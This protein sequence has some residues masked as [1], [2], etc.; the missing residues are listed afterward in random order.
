MKKK[1]IMGVLTGMILATSTGCTTVNAVMNEESLVEA[2]TTKTNDNVEEFFNSVQ[3]LNKLILS[4]GTDTKEDMIEILVHSEDQ[5]IGTILV[6]KETN[7]DKFDNVFFND[8]KGNTILTL[9]DVEAPKSSHSKRIGLIHTINN[10]LVGSMSETEPFEIPQ[11][12]LSDEVDEKED[13]LIEAMGGPIALKT[14]FSVGNETD[15][16]YELYVKDG[17]TVD[18]T[19]KFM[20]IDYNVTVSLLYRDDKLIIVKHPKADT[21]YAAEQPIENV[22]MLMAKVLVEEH[23]K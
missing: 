16:A 2:A 23:L 13:E 9:E 19:L 11:E 15:Y 12:Y 17:S 1:L 5:F 20:D 21:P 3:D 7:T 4:K 18:K 14:T 8:S 10:K 6:S 22:A